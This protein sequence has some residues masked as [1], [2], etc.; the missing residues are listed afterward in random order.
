FNPAAERTFG[1]P[2]RQVLGKPLVE[3]LVPEPLREKHLHGFRRYLE[4]GEGPILGQRIEIDALRAGGGIFPVELAVVRI[5]AHDPPTF[6]AYIR[7]LSERKRAEEA[8]ASS[9]ARAEK[10]SAARERA[11]ATL[12]ETAEQ[13]RQAQKMEAIGRLAGGVAHDFN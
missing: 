2:R 11:E 3:L 12:H 13:L 7:D 8:K 5:G 4:T 10:E 1:Y 6:T 9:T